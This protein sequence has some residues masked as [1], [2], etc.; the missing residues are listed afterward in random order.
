VRAVFELYTDVTADVAR[1]GATACACCS[2]SSRFRRVLVVL[3]LIVRRADQ[4]LRSVRVARAS[5]GALLVKS[6]ELQLA[7]AACGWPRA[8]SS[9]AS[10][11]R[12]RRYAAQRG[13]GD[14]AFT[15]IPATQSR[16]DRAQAAAVRVDWHDDAFTRR[17]ADGAHSGL[18]AG[19]DHRPAQDGEV[20]NQ[21]LTVSADFIRERRHRPLHR[22]VLRRHEKAARRGEDRAAA[23]YDALTGLANRRLFEDRVEHALQLARR[24]QTHVAVDVHRPRPLQ[25]VNDSLGHKAGDVCWDAG[26]R[27]ARQHRPRL[28]HDGT[29]GATSS[30]C[31]CRSTRDGRSETGQVAQRILD[32]LSAPLRCRSH[33]IIPARA[34]A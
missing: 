8:S 9:A 30:R 28:R 4:I 27:A 32:A 14:R 26:R 6:A 5:E 11:H 1:S 31:C 33:E 7:N 19:R 16:D 2:V 29:V 15:E 22:D 18:V 34:S 24:Q 23:Y 17:V 3:M 12:H 10:G 25:A 20:Y 13:R 21:W